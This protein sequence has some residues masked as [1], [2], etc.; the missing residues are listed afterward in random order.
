MQPQQGRGEAPVLLS[1]QVGPQQLAAGGGGIRQ[2]G[3]PTAAGTGAGQLEFEEYV[4][5]AVAVPAAV[6]TPGRPG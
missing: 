4:V 1:C 6:R 3:D 2:G 5:E